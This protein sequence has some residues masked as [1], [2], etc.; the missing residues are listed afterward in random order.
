MR[1]ALDSNV[2]LYAEGIGDPARKV[3]AD[4]L[5]N[6]LPAE[7]TYLSVQVIGELYNVLVKRGRPRERA[8]AA[9]VFWRNAF[10]LIATPPELM[11]SALELATQHRLNIW[12]AL[13]LSAAAEASCSILLSE[14]FQDGFAWNGVTVCNPFAAT[15]H[16]LAADLLRELG[17]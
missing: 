8:L 16:P 17:R 13:I 4:R 3:V 7:E 9:A 5:A 10:S 15:L 2:L 1:V 14:D 6:I 11:V 12:D